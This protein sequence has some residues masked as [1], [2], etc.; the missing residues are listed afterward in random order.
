MS[1]FQVSEEEVKR[2]RRLEEKYK[3]LYLDPEH[4]EPLV[5][6]S[7][8]VS[9]CPSV[10]DQFHDPQK[11][12]D[13]YAK[14]IKMH[15]EIQDDVLPMTRVEFGTAQIAAAFGCKIQEMPGSLPACGS[16]ALADLEDVWKKEPPTMQDGLVPLLDE[17]TQYFLSHQPVEIPIQHPDVQS[18]FNSGHLIR[19][20]DIL[21]DFYDEP[22]AVHHLLKMVT[23]YMIAFT[24]H[25]KAPISKDREWFY[26]SGGLWKGAA[27]I[28]NC[29]LQI[30]SP[31]IYR[32][33]IMEE[34]VRYL[35]TIGG[36]RVHYCGN[37]P[38]VIDEFFKEP[39]V[40]HTIEI[41]SQ[42]HD[43]VEICDRCPQKVTMMFCDWSN[44]RGNREWLPKLLSGHVPAKKNV[45]INAKAY[46]VEEAKRTY[47]QIKNALLRG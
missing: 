25:V 21:Y 7:I 29:T 45:V 16:H 10:S 19:G 11:M 13:A 23:D 22:E 43:I 33:F 36:G 44:E 18:T 17:Y 1:L 27:R 6:I 24:E 2:Y 9:G 8:P 41:D 32:E 46:T 34:D 14:R 39:D 37:H 47:D 30:V 3:A 12:L 20:N 38:G 35:K 42:Y 5:M 26:D 15:S 31:D 40:M 28:S 4:C